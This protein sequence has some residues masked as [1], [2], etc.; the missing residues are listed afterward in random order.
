MY[1]V[2]YFSVLDKQFPPLITSVVL[3]V[4]CVFAIGLVIGSLLT[5]I[6]TSALDCLLFC[7]LI[8]S[9]SVDEGA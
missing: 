6:F 8:E 3:P 4:F 2:V 1:F 7:Y 5:N 9:R